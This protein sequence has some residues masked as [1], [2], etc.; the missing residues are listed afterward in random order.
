MIV[1]EKSM[2]DIEHY[3]LLHIAMLTFYVQMY[4]QYNVTFPLQSEN[5]KL[6]IL[7]KT[8]PLSIIFTHSHDYYCF[9]SVQKK[10]LE[11]LFFDFLRVSTVWWVWNCLWRC[12]AP[13]CIAMKCWLSWKV[14]ELILN[15]TKSSGT[16]SKGENQA[17]GLALFS[18]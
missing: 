17:W 11:L 10:I 7:V 6:A 8:R 18:V 5:L 2:T 15:K 1:L 13:F 16:G 14:T 9:G 12:S 4:H 3:L